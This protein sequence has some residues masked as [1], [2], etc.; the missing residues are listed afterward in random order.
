MSHPLL[1]DPSLPGL[2]GALSLERMSAELA[3]LAAH[4]SPYPSAGWRVRAV[5]VLKYKPARRCALAYTLES[6][7]GSLR[8]FAKTFHSHRGAA[9]L[10][11]MD[12]FWR[13]LDLQALSIPRPL[14]YVSD[15][16]LLVTEFVSGI[17]LATELYR[18]SSAEPARRMARALAAVHASAVSCAQ[19]WTSALELENSE[20]WIRGLIGHPALASDRA[21]GLLDRLRRWSSVLRPTPPRPIHRDFYLDQLLDSDGR[22]VLVDLDDARSGDPAL[23]VGNFLAHLVLRPIQFPETAAACRRA[24]DCFESEYRSRAPVEEDFR[25]RT[26]FYEA[27]SLLRLAGVYAGRQR[28]SESVPTPL[29]DACERMLPGE[30]RVQ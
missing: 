11:T 18:G 22:T 4:L 15:L 28:W 3:P 10:M 25:I 21:L 2:A 17:P 7:K 16:K 27:S 19:Q 29:L 14:G 5:D 12:R 8:L 6:P 1:I 13:A 24:R 23:D 26:R 30:R 20:K 9:I